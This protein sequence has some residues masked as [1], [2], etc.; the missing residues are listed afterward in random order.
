MDADITVLIVDDHPS[1]RIGLT[2]ILES[3]P[4]LLLVGKAETAREAIDLTIKLR[5]HI[6]LMDIQLPDM[7]GLEATRRLMLENFDPP[8]V[9]I[10][11]TF[12]D[13][14]YLVEAYQSGA[15]GYLLKTVTDRELERKIRNVVINKVQE[16]PDRVLQ[17]VPQYEALKRQQADEV[18]LARNLT[19]SEIKVLTLIY[20]GF[21][22]KESARELNVAK[23]T[24]KRHLANAR[25]KL[26]VE[27]SEEAAM[28]AHRVGLI[29]D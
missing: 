19:P 12:D 11:T 10:L 15:S 7:T 14:D 16:W 24:V 18:R 6:I 13:D 21:S 9:L 23:D 28:L 2:S 25:A 3:T 5:P 27:S 4:G 1:V 17:L 22:Y 29:K 26:G 8:K 20:H